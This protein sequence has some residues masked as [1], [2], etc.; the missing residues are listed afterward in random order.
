MPIMIM[1]V[2][3]VVFREDVNIYDMTSLP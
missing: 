1:T 2:K 3:D